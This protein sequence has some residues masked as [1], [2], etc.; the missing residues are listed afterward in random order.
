MR[1]A[2]LLFIASAMLFVAQAQDDELKG[3]AAGVSGQSTD[4]EEDGWDKGGIINVNF[5][6]TSLS[7]WTAGGEDAIAINGIFNAYA[8]YKKGKFFWN[9]FLDV[10]YGVINTASFS[11]FRKNND[12]LN[13]RSKVG[14]QLSGDWFLAAMLD[15]RTQLAPGYNYADTT[16]N[17]YI[18]NFLAPGYILLPI[19][20]DY[21]PSDNF[22]LFFSPATAKF[23]II[24]DGGVNEQAFGLDSGAIVRTEIG[25]YLALDY[26]CKI[27]ENITFN[28]HAD[29]YTNYLENLG[30]I[31]VNWTAL[32]ALKVNEYISASISTHLI[33]DDDIKL[34][35]D[36]GTVGPA[37][38]FKEV[39]AVGFSYKF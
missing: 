6:Q 12:L 20:L 25:A 34:T 39:L 32:L 5:T 22:S 33:Y 4:Q 26:K 13:F 23:T 35:R 9:N 16:N 36:D 14:N 17:G 28:T 7:N 15:F 11:G 3:N 37:V 38:Q 21:K 8:N 2:L 30:N 1:K 19:G 18:T 24:A 10:Q 29:F 27:M 31:D